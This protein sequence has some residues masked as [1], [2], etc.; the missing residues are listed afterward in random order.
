M[1]NLHFI[2]P[3]YKTLALSFALLIG[4]ASHL[5]W[6]VDPVFH[7]GSERLAIRGYDTVAYFTQKEP[8]QGHQRYQT[9]WQGATWRFASQKNLDLF[10]SSPQR[11]APQYGGYCAYAVSKGATASIQPDAWSVVN[12]KL[13]LNYG[14]AVRALWKRDT[15]GNI[16]KADQHWPRIL[17]R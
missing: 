8:V 2:K 7:T 1:H 5:A 4:A 12:D 15:K 17:K 13:Y 3:L 16:Q 14:I 11:Y 6:A 10:K 9:Q